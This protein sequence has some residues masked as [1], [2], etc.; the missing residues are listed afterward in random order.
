MKTLISLIR[1][2]GSAI[3]LYTTDC[4]AAENT[5]LPAP[6]MEQALLSKHQG[7]KLLNKGDAEGAITAYQKAVA[8]DS[9]LAPAWFNLAIARYAKRDLPGTVDALNQVI[10]LNDNDSEAH[11]NL[12]CVWLYQGNTEQARRHFTKAAHCPCVE[13]FLAE[14]I[15]KATAYLDFYESCQPPQRSKIL[16]LLQDGLEPLKAA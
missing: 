11:Y 12:G 16:R 2:I 7:D 8:S 13:E 14:Q 3:L 10:L 1:I 4:L 15:S 9:H 6:S 5:I